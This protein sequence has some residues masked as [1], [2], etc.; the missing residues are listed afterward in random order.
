MIIAYDKFDQVLTRALK[1]S[2]ICYAT[3]ADLSV[4]D[5]LSLLT[6]IEIELSL[7]LSEPVKKSVLYASNLDHKLLEECY[8]F[9]DQI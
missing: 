8:Q 6:T 9:G 7:A 1:D 5:R 4:R 2:A 3:L